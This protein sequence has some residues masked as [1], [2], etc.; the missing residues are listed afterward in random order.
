MASIRKLASKNQ[1]FPYPY[2]ADIGGVPVRLG[3]KEKGAGTIITIDPAPDA[4]SRVRPSELGDNPWAP[5]IELRT[6]W[7][8]F[9]LGMGAPEQIENP[10][11]DKRYYWADKVDAGT[12]Y[13]TTGPVMTSYTP[14]TTDSTYGIT[15]MI[16]FNGVL[17]AAGGRY[18]LSWS[19]ANWNTVTKDFGVGM[20]ITD[21]QVIS[22]SP[23]ATHLY[24]MLAGNNVWHRMST[25]GVWED[26][27]AG[28]VT[29]A[30]CIQVSE[31]LIWFGW[32]NNGANTV[33]K[34]LAGND[35]Y[36]AAG[37]NVVTYDFGDATTLVNNLNVT[38]TDQLLVFKEEGIYEM[39]SG[40]GDAANLFPSLDSFRH[41]QNGKVAEYFEDK[42]YTRYGNGFFRFGADRTIEPIGVDQLIRSTIPQGPVT[43][44]CAHGTF[45]A[46]AGLHDNSSNLDGALLKFGAWMPTNSISD[47]QSNTAIHI[48]AWHG[49]L[50]HV[51]DKDI[52]KL[53][54]S[55]IGPS[56]DAIATSEDLPV[57]WLGL[58]DGTLRVFRLPRYPGE[59][60]SAASDN[61]TLYLP[62]FW[63][64]I[65]GVPK[66]FHALEIEG[67]GTNNAGSDASQLQIEYRLDGTGAFQAL[68]T[69]N[70]AVIGTTTT[71]AFPTSLAIAK[72]LEL[73]LVLVPVSGGNPVLK[74]VSLTYS[75][76]LDPREMLELYVLCDS[77]LRLRSQAR[78]PR[79]GE[80]IVTAVGA[81][82]QGSGIY[83]ITLQDK[84]VKTVRTLKWR[85]TAAWDE[86]SSDW[87]NAYLLQVV[88]VA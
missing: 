13:A 80:D 27:P 81:I 75:Y 11:A 21:L 5:E 32:V 9:S 46:Y 79:H 42:I 25:A 30:R 58:S 24:V 62:K 50:W 39:P 10:E 6:T 76:W 31:G 45:F 83:I 35:P 1:P 68:T 28:T 33:A 26:A 63:G 43:A 57:M 8:D 23:T 51:D 22:W 15:H 61:G 71:V 12:G 70:L 64:Q 67:Y 66:H 16:E 7:S 17:Y 19:G 65:R 37:A 59:Q 86:L 48:D 2:D 56:I 53:Y 44:F 72:S 36:T 14:T 82:V 55:K 87:K 52:K 77:G 18:L 60:G 73:K 69:V 20:E 47:A 49:A 78:D 41:S 38:A 29:K 88:E 74:R 40:G 85:Q 3:E 4:A 34:V 54:K 84:P